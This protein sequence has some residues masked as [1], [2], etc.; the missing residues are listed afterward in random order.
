MPKAILEFDL[1]EENAEWEKALRAGRSERALH[2]I[3]KYL[4]STTKHPP[5]DMPA[6]VYR[7]YEDVYSK[8]WEILRDNEVDI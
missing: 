3:Y 5:E 4:K 6:D 1:P 8:F 2:D 7:A